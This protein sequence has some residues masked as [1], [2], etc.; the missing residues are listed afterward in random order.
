MASSPEP[1]ATYVPWFTRRPEVALAGMAG[2]FVLVTGLRIMLGNDAAVGITMLY[3]VP[4]SL[5][6]LAYGRAAGV[7]AAVVAL[8]ALLTWVELA[9]VRLT[10]LGWVAR[11]VPLLLAGFLL[12]DTSDR[13]RRADAARVAQVQRELLHRQAVEIN[14]SLLQGMAV[15]KWALEAGNHD[16][17]LKNLTETI[18]TGQKLVSGL[19]KESAMGP[20]DPPTAS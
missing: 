16:L 8:A 5:A 14:D 6:A 18:G 10:T 9:D 11:I 1:P 17:A 12:G 13:L 20:L 3:V 2:M 4:I 15:T 7:V 19:I